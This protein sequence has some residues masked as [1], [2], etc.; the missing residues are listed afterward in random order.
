MAIL[1]DSNTKVLVQGITGKQGSFHT[2][3]MKEYGTKILAGVTPGKGG[4]KIY[5]VPVYDTV[6]EAIKDYPDINTSIVFVPAPF[7]QDAVIEAV[8]AGLKLIVVI[9]ERVPMHD[10]MFFVNYARARNAK[11]IGPNCPGI[12]SPPYSKVGIMPAHLFKQGHIGLISRSGTLTYE[13]AY[14]LARKGYGISTAVGIGGDAIIGTDFIEIYTMFLEDKATDAVVVIGE[15]GGD[16]EERF[17][18]FYS[19][20]N[21]KKPVVAFIAGRSA[22]EGKRMGHAGAIVSMGVGSAESKINSFK[23]ANIPVADFLDDIPALLN[24]V[25]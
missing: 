19:K 16:M 14:R 12:I 5:D 6:F 18:E 8:D 23:K 7:A 3:L 22:P 2:K 4:Q 20:L 13:V 24:K 9:T 17:S 11:I 1:I 21:S 25:L 15:I 10:E